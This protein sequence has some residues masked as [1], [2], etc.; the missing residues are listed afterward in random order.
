MSWRGVLGWALLLVAMALLAPVYAHPVSS[1]VPLASRR[2]IVGGDADFPPYEF[3]GPD[4]EPTGFDVELFLAVAE[5]MDLQVQ[6]ELG[7]WS[8]VRERFEAGELDAVV[9]MHYSVARDERLD[10]SNPYAVAHYAVFVREGED[11]IAGVHDLKGRSVLV[12]A[13]ALM[14]DM[15]QQL[16]IS[17]GLVPVRGPEQ[18]L[19]SLARGEHDAALLFHHQG[20]YLAAELELDG[21]EV[22][23]KP[24]APEEYCFA[25]HEGDT[26]LL[27]ALNEGLAVV[28]TTGRYQE[29]QTR[30]LGVLEPAGWSWQRTLEIVAWI[31]VPAALAVLLALLWAW[32]LQR[33]VQERTR[34]LVDQ[35]AE[36]RRAEAALAQERERLLVTLRSIGDA[37]VTTDSEGRVELMNRVAETLLDSSLVE[38]RGTRLDALLPLVDASDGRPLP[39]L[40]D[41]LLGSDAERLVVHAARLDRPLGPLVSLV[42]APILDHQLRRQGVVVALRDVT[43]QHRMEQELIRAEKLESVGVLAGG[44]AH[45]F[46]NILTGV[47]G[48]LSIGRAQ[49]DDEHGV[50]HHL[51][52]AE[53]ATLRAQGLTKQLLTFSKGGVPVRRVLAF[54]PLLRDAVELALVGG[55]VASRV[56]VTPGLWPVEA[57]AGQVSQVLHNLLIN[58]SQAMPDG[59]IIAL[60]VENLEL[61]DGHHS[62]LPAGRYL[63]V[64]VRDQGPGIPPHV[65]E[66]IFEPFFTTK[67]QGSG[68]GLATAYSIAQQHGGWLG[69]EAHAGAGAWFLWLLPAMPGAVPVQGEPE[70]PP[71]AGTGRVLVMDD[72]EIVREVLQAMLTTMGYEVDLS[73]D[74]EQ[75]VQAYQR[76][77]EGHDPYQVVVMDLTVPGGMGG[78][79]AMAAIRSL[80]PD[81]R[82][83]VSS[84]FSDDPVMADPGRFG[85]CGVVGKPYRLAELSAAVR[86][87]LRGGGL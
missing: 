14:E 50:Q 87:A 24:L 7:P 75:A 11:R 51:E 65:A 17:A 69:L 58:A 27:T 8:E 31:A 64:R 13:G 56:H 2:L 23:G 81:A 5:V 41:R 39:V 45:D 20:L 40:L 36:R 84:G 78:V 80:D 10:F 22:V 21:V 44:I 86:D 53:V 46:N 82:G 28:E 19:R 61:E 66:S 71:T 60:R 16:G 3:L 67:D 59:G 9:G 30:W 57:D 77:M 76:A 25:V 79:E 48:H 15:A 34:E 35:L 6:L 12:Q 63:A 4:G 62:G 47:L 85:F 26:Q 55:T 83:I 32:L 74:G 68:L 42:A 72:E 73:S 38:A 1:D 18:A 49:L 29:L 33:R 70:R 43:A 52:R 54:E 37:V